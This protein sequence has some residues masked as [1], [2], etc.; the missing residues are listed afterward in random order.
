ML[1]VTRKGFAGTVTSY[2]HGRGTSRPFFHGCGIRG[3][4]GGRHGRCQRDGFPRVP[5]N[6]P[7]LGAP[8]LR[9]GTG[10]AVLK[11]VAVAGRRAGSFAVSPTGAMACASFGKII[12]MRNR[13]GGTPLYPCLA[14]GAARAT[15]RPA[16]HRLQEKAGRS[17]GR[18]C[19][20]LHGAHYTPG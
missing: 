17:G 15:A 16:P 4:F 6:G 8:G 9:F 13:Q 7:H 10:K 19:D 1:L 2:N 5:D 18:K 12:V 14:P 20:P 11:G 3:D